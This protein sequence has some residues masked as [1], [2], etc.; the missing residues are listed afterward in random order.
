MNTTRKNK[1]TL[2]AIF[3]AF[4]LPIVLAAYFYHRGEPI[5]ELTNRGEL[6]QP[7]LQLSTIAPISSK[8]IPRK[9]AVMVY[10]AQNIYSPK[11]DQFL[12]QL[13]QLWKATGKHMNDT[14]IL[15]L[16]DSR[17]RSDLDIKINK[18][19]SMHRLYCN[20][21]KF[22]EQPNQIFLCDPQGNV[23][24]RYSDRVSLDD[25]YHDLSK[26]LRINS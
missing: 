9:W 10:S 4:T 17:M 22:T 3:I 13:N 18:Y 19:P 20:P 24:M 1:L 5:G 15:I 16:T 23:M 6:I 26:L 12:Y 25:V 8:D 21:K 11:P 7:P 2:L 14:Q